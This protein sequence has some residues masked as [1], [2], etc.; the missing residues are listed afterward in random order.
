M[1]VQQSEIPTAGEQIVWGAAAIAKVIGHTETATFA[2]L[3][4]GKLPGARKVGRR[5]A[6]NPKIFFTSFETA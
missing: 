5:W 3:E 6:F 2:M 1:S 4:R